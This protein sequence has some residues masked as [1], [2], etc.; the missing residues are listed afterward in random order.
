MCQ[1]FKISFIYPTRL[2]VP[3]SMWPQLKERVLSILSEVKMGSPLDRENL[4][5]AVIDAKVSLSKQTMK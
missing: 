4:V 2:Y 3:E 1:F 5:T